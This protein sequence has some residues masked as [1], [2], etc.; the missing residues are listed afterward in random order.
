MPGPAVLHAPPAVGHAG[1]LIARTTVGGIG[2]LP[3]MWR[4]M[5]NVAVSAL[6]KGTNADGLPALLGTLRIQ[7][8]PPYAAAARSATW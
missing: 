7:D 3:Q 4:G 1:G 8:L 5:L 2:S 6:A